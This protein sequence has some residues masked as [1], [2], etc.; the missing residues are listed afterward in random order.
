[1]KRTVDARGVGSS[2]FPFS[3]PLGG[4]E[5]QLL[6]CPA[7]VDMVPGWHCDLV[8]GGLLGVKVGGPQ[9][10]NGSQQKTPA[11]E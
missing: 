7:R 3:S 10:P 9:A 6:V 4:V 1:M 11:E 5:I 8:E 2:K